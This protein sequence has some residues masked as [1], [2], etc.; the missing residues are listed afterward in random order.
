MFFDV[1]FS[2]PK[3]VYQQM[4][5]QV[6]LEVASGRLKPGDKLPSVREAAM[7]ARVNRNTIARVYGELEREGVIYTRAGQ[8]AFISEKGS[9]LSR[10]V[11]R[12]QLVERL[13]DLIAQ[14]RLYE[15]RRGDLAR[16]IDE[17]LDTIYGADSAPEEHG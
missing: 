6:K 12:E 14:A 7:Q 3:A 2:N 1:D 11:R 8:G 13:D 5:D 17:R 15:Y 16:L 9:A 4:T 10:E